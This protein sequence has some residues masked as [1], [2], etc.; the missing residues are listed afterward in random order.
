MKLS[1][2]GVGSIVGEEDVFNRSCYSCNLKCIS[3]I[4]KVFVIKKEDFLNLKNQEESWVGI[5]EKIQVKEKR[6]EGELIGTN[7]SK[8]E[9]LITKK[10]IKANPNKMKQDFENFMRN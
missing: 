2:F 6:R 4:G 5:I 10:T 7:A 8:N 1:I 9:D 3:L